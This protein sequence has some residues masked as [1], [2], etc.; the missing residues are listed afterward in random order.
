VDLLF[1]GDL[2]SSDASAY[3]TKSKMQN[4][5][6]W[7]ELR[8][9]ICFCLVAQKR[10]SHVEAFLH[11]YRILELVSVALPLIY[12]TKFNDFRKG[13]QFIK[14]LSQNDRDQD[15]SILKHFSQE[16]AQGTSVFSSLEID[17][18]FDGHDGS[19]RHHLRDQLNKFVLSDKKILHSGFANQLDG[20]SVEF[21]CVSSFIVSCRNRLFHN[22]LSNEN[23]KLDKMQ[24]G[25]AICSV[26]VGPGLHWFSLILS[27]ILKV[28]ASRYV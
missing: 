22:A 20:V 28:E 25:A 19:V 23:F 9:E 3:L 14:S 2:K 8:A 11:F 4:R 13:V 1:D 21:K 7:E 27:E 24:G 10:D 26:L 6:F 5:E 18:P 16:V 15:L 12:A 17:F